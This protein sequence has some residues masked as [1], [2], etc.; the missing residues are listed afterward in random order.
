MQTAHVSLVP[1]NR[2]HLTAIVHRTLSHPLVAKLFVVKQILSELGA[3]IA[4]VNLTL[5]V[6]LLVHYPNV[7][8]QVI[9]RL[10][11]FVAEFTRQIFL[12]VFL[13]DVLL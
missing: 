10:A 7:I 8:C 12:L 6:A 11:D 5:K 9:P 3:E 4:V 2:N 1:S 13:F